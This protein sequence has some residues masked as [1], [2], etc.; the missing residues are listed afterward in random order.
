MELAPQ[1]LMHGC[2]LAPTPQI[3]EDC[4]S[5]GHVICLAEEGGMVPQADELHVLFFPYD[6]SGFREVYFFMHAKI[7]TTHI[8][9]VFQ[10][11]LVVGQKLLPQHFYDP[12]AGEGRER[13]R[14]RE[15]GADTACTSGRLTETDM[16]PHPATSLPMIRLALTSIA[17]KVRVTVLLTPSLS[18][19]PLVHSRRGGGRE[20]WRCGHGQLPSSTSHEHQPQPP[21]TGDR[22]G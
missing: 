22:S 16:A 20:R 6:T 1:R 5:T 14:E 11:F 2:V 10:G 19:P 15:R 12:S 21:R 9:Q 4:S 8:N 3:V 7:P 13:E 18:V 17:R